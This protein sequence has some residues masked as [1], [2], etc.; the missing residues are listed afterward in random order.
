MKFLHQDFQKLTYYR[1][2]YTHTYRQTDRQ[3][4]TY[5]HC[6]GEKKRKYVFCNIFYKTQVILIK[7]G[8]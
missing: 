5:T 4:D 7:S 1:Q 6:L 3:T 2:T 8:T